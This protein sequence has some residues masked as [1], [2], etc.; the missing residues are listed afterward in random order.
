[1]NTEAAG[2]TLNPDEAH[3]A[4]RSGPRSQGLPRDLVLQARPRLRVMALLYAAVFLLAGIFPSLLTEVNRA[5]L[6]GSV[7]QWLPATISIAVALF[8][9]AA[10]TNP[11]LSPRAAAAIAIV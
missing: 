10:V 11:R 1:M 5:I 4:W 7:V 9:A 2:P 6:F 3:R 8:V